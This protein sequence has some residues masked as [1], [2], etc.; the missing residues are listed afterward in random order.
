MTVLCTEEN[1]LQA[2]LRH[3]T[4]G[5]FYC[6]VGEASPSLYIIVGDDGKNHAVAKFRFTEGVAL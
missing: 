4:F 3:I 6:V 1:E 2:Q 5:K